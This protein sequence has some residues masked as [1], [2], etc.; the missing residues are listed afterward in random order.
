VT[1]A[2]KKC[3]GKKVKL[4]IRKVKRVLTEEKYNEGLT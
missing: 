1:K 2:L 4:K 3:Q